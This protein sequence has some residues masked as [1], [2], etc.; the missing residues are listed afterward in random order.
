MFA[1]IYCPDFY[2]QC[3]R[4]FNPSLKSQAIIVIV[5]DCAGNSKIIASSTE[6]R[7]LGFWPGLFGTKLADA[8]SVL[9]PNRRIRKCS[10]NYELYADLSERFIKSIE[11][12]TPAASVYSNDEVFLSLH[13]VNA[14]HDLSNQQLNDYAK[15]LRQSLKQWS[16]FSVVIGLAPT[17][18]L[19]KL[20]SDAALRFD[21]Y[22][23]VVSISDSQERHKVLRRISVT[24]INGISDNAA[25]KLSE[26]NVHTALELSTAPKTQLRRCC[27]TVIESIALELSGL[28][29]NELD[30]DISDNSSVCALSYHAAANTVAE[31]KRI[32]NKEIRS[33]AQQL[34][35]PSK[36]YKSV[37]IGLATTQ[38]KPEHPLRRNALTAELPTSSNSITAIERLASQLIESLWRDNHQYHS[39]LISIKQL[40]SESENQR[41]LFTGNV[42]ENKPNPVLHESIN[43]EVLFSPESHS[44]QHRRQLLPSP[45]Y[46]TKWADILRV[47]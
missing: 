21:E 5:N 31:A 25:S 45:S 19:A 7:D 18:T 32:I 46:T 11:L 33:I 22:E 13:N 29:C 20:A 17:K 38:L 36:L 44:L 47:S 6:A 26:I 3:E 39:L 2:I 1:V 27:S 28:R 40:S 8:F 12:L 4:L 34:E 15:Q 24:D 41:R 23:G 30:V 14:I 43:V 42:L 9:P 35:S 16:G 10:P 37:T